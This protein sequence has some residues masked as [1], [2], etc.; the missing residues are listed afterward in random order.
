ME[1]SKELIAIIGTTA[2]GKTQLSARLALLL[3]AEIISADS[4]QVYR[5][6]DIGTGK[7]LNEYIIGGQHVGYHLIDIIEPTEEYNIYRYKND[8]KQAL[9]LIRSKSKPAIICGGSG[10]YVDSVIR[11]IDFHEVQQDKELRDRLQNYSLEQLVDL[12]KTLKD[13]HNTTDITDRGRCIRAIEIEFGKNKAETQVRNEKLNINVFGVK[14]SRSETRERI[15]SRLKL[16]LENGMIEEVENLIPKVGVEKLLFF[17]LEY[18]YLTSYITGVLTYDEM[19]EKLNIAIH[20]FAKRQDT[21]WR[22]ME[23][24]GVNINWL[25]GNKSIEEKIKEI[26]AL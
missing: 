22:F 11:N 8:F 6:M 17:G 15:T 12:L 26:L 20:Q 21:Y 9:K 23:K 14:Y 2:C 7:D 24:K 16:R 3:G 5:G 1:N 4:R 13:V 10:M 18:R 25:D 19:F